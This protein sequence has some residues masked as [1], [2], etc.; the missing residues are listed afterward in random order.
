MSSSIFNGRIT[1][2]D[3]DL[4]DLSGGLLTIWRGTFD[5]VD[6]SGKYLGTNVQVGD[7]VVLDTSAVDQGTVTTF[8]IIAVGSRTFNQFTVDFQYIPSNSNPAGPPDVFG[9]IA[10]PGYITRTSDILKLA[11]IPSP[12][13]QQLP[14]L[15][16]FHVSNDNMFN[17][18]DK[19]DGGTGTGGTGTTGTGTVTSISASGGETGL[20]ITGG[21]ITT[22]GNLV[23]GGVL[24][25]EHGGT[26]TDGLVGFLFGN[27]I[28]PFTASPTIPGS[29]IEGDITGIA[30][31]I[32]G[33]LPISQGGT[34][35]INSVDALNALL[36]IQ[37]TFQGGVLT[38]NGTDAFWEAGTNGTVTR[39]DASGGTT[40]LTFT[41]GPI[42]IEGT[43]TL[44]GVL[45]LAN[46]GTGNATGIAAGISGIL[47]I[48][49]GGTGEV[50]SVD[51]LNA[52]LPVQTTFQG[53]VLTTNGTNVTWEPAAIGTVTS[54]S[55]IA[56]GGIQVTGGPIT[57]SGTLVFTLTNISPESI[58]SFGPITGS[59][60]TGTNTGDQTIVLAGDATGSGTGLINVVLSSNGV[61]P[62][63]YGGSTTI[64]TFTVDASGRIT[65]IAT[66]P[67]V[68]SPGSD[69]GSV[70]SVSI[71]GDHGVEITGDTITTSGVFSIGLG[72][73]T[74][75][76]VES[77][78]PITGL[79]LSGT[80]TGDQIIT[81]GGDLAG[82]GTSAI[83]VTLNDTGV[84]PG[85]YGSAIDVPSIVVDSKGRI[86]AISTIAIN[87]G[88]VRSVE[89]SGQSGIVVE[90]GPI[91][92][93]GTIDIS[94]GNITPI[95]V[96]ASGNISAANFAGNSSGTN[97]GDQNIK[98]VGDVI[99]T[100]V[101]NSTTSI[102]TISTELAESGV[103]AGT[104]GSSL[105]V[106]V[107]TVDDKGRITGVVTTPIAVNGVVTYVDISG[108][109]TGLSATG[110]PIVDAGTLT[111]GGRLNI[112]SGG[113]GSTT[114]E[115]ARV[116]LGAAT[117]GAN[118]DITSL[119]GLTTP[120]SITQGGTGATTPADALS[121]L[122]P[123]Q[124]TKAGFLLVTNGY[125][126]E[127]ES[128]PQPPLTYTNIAVGNVNNVASGNS[129]FTWN[130]SGQ[131]L[132]MGVPTETPLIATN[133]LTKVVTP[134][135]TTLTVQ[136][137]TT[138]GQSGVAGSLNLRAGD[139]GPLGGNQGYPVTPGEVYIQAGASGSTYAPG[140]NVYIQGGNG[141]GSRYV[142]PSA[143]NVDILGGLSTWTVP[144]GYV[145]IL[146]A[147][148]Y[149]TY[150]ST[151]TM[152]RPVMKERLR[153]KHNGAWSIGP[154]GLETGATGDI[155][156]SNG[157]DAPPTWKT[158]DIGLVRSVDLSGGTTG[159]TVE[160][161][162][163][164][165]TGTFTLGGELA[166][167]SGGT[168][169]TTRTGALNA[170]LPAQ[171]S[172]TTGYVL[173]SNGTDAYWTSTD[174]GT[175]SSVAAT[176]EHGILIDGGPIT[177][178]GTLNFRLGN[179]TPTSVITTGIINGANLSGINTGDQII[180]LTGDVIGSGT[181]SISA[182]LA[183]TG[184]TAGT[185]GSPTQVAVFTVDAGGRITGVS[186][187]NIVTTGTGTVT[188]V[189]VAT[190]N[191]ILVS[192]GPITSSG[193]IQLT[194]GDITPTSV[195]SSGTIL[196]SNLAGTN[197]GDQTITLTGD[198]TGSGRN[199]FD[200]T[201]SSSGVTAGTY[202]ST[203][204][205]P[206]ITVDAK[207]RVTNATMTTIP[208][209]TGT[210]TSVQANGGNGVLVT[211][212]PI[213][214]N[215]TFTISLGSITPTSILTSGSI[216][217]T[218][219]LTGSNFSGNSTGTNSGDQYITLM[220]DVTGNGS[221][222]FNTTLSNT[223]V[224]P[225]SY[226]NVN[227]TVDSK[228]RIT[229]ATNGTAGGV[230][231]GSV[232]SVA[233]SG[234]NGV[235]V[236]GSPIT[237]AGTI[238]VTLGDI[239]PTKIMATGPISGTNLAGTN[240]GDQTIVLTGDV[241]GA[242]TGTFTTALSATGVAAGVYGSASAIPVL[243]VDAKGRVISATTVAS[244]GGGT[245]GGGMVRRVVDVV[246]NNVTGKLVI[247]A[248]GSQTDLNAITVTLTG[249]NTLTLSTVPAGLQ[250]Q[251]LAMHY[252]INF[253][254]TTSF[255]VRYPEVFGDPS[256]DI[257]FPVMIYMNE[258]GAGPLMN[259]VSYTS[260]GGVVQVTRTGMIA[261]TGAKFRVLMM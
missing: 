166:I 247:V 63:T 180:S 123:P 66:I 87:V 48:S 210:V 176:G 153:F 150:D 212:G 224:V 115:A 171:S 165:T 260:V 257:I 148:D 187:T 184:V 195:Q 34:G 17:I 89:I 68:G 160:G 124:G 98:I 126:A 156:T 61:T 83:E 133:A 45:S 79:N 13:L 190:A 81:L 152:N 128:A 240:T 204:S 51:A 201:L 255:V 231:S 49:Q 8:E 20:S 80:N 67:I 60:L 36:P 235:L 35:Q 213:T 191:G 30:A 135:Y 52:L 179:I 97:T 62:G 4:I 25:V 119:S 229:A 75:T 223:G 109:N 200:T 78:G 216:V 145:R 42:S 108:G 10:V 113:T 86:T 72:D 9:S 220:G 136:A 64:P 24:N 161:G 138:G 230:G 194:L 251:T 16:S 219:T 2:T 71:L 53:G 31:G 139:S 141:S 234:G 88:S 58:T 173:A 15:F 168:G 170:L 50:N 174:S 26:G 132:S 167:S 242:G 254:P 175:V 103:M 249:G 85:S 146:T 116:A 7:I 100:G 142:P 33:I 151:G 157:A 18:V 248:I 14:D 158:F 147:N 44:G 77:S 125:T 130:E 163:I 101:N 208:I 144:G 110:G 186:S 154:T 232:T 5:F 38:T 192:G 149:F 221:A 54:I 1:L 140:G 259:N 162:P 21:P 56:S 111:L 185:Y 189:A 237:S 236:S 183:A 253:N 169:Q 250:L 134:L 23:L 203:S 39:I 196:G 261:N 41:G 65:S 127:W 22:Q 218:G 188:S 243:T 227:L 11:G 206:I 129:S 121:A 241:M 73:I 202:G 90:G 197:T 99:G 69:I 155:L 12:G 177:S 239:T 238:A 102:T 131:T 199:T 70:T 105:N 137:G 244:T 258:A 96:I 228:G 112:A 222:T 117:S 104:Y 217:A 215:G 205:I 3:S 46:G 120:L 57:E 211:G 256:L 76:S 94:L 207:G 47:P 91:T 226:T 19:L 74:P 32:A 27:G 106:P 172:P 84:I 114:A 107:F 225:G 209:G 245:S 43:L 214:T 29:L 143:G 28:A 159:L 40:G 233:L 6:N 37:T 118:S 164:T 182:R 59:N 252:S 82:T 92:T 122:L 193:T 246:N 93:S 95:S 55:A 178:A 198:I 181:G